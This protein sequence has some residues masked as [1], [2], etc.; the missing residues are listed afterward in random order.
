MS[1]IEF[2]SK[3]GLNELKNMDY[4]FKKII[5]INEEIDSTYNIDCFAHLIEGSEYLICALPSAQSSNSPIQNP[6][7]HRWSW[8]KSFME[9]SYVCL[10]DPALY[11]ALIAGTWFMNDGEINLIEEISQFIVQLA[12][13]SNIEQSKIIFY[14]SSMGGFG[15]LLLATYIEGSIAIAEVP[16][17]D[18]RNYPFKSAITSLEENI[19]N[20]KSF[21]TFAIEH[22]D[23]VDVLSKILNSNI[24]P[25][26]KIITNDKD[27]A[28]D[29]HI[30]FFSEV[31]SHRESLL[32]VGTCSICISPKSIGHRPLPSSEG[33]NLIKTTIQEGWAV[34]E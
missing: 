11:K 2:E 33:I 20:G 25:S 15:S 12:E 19:L 30:T 18:M 26:F 10:S 9:I 8:Y 22:I 27:S 6:V 23:R 5:H 21:E 1:Q 34:K 17:L 13:I 3:V 4:K 28:F 32:S 31:N 14:G 24:I 16:Q 7:F 29:E